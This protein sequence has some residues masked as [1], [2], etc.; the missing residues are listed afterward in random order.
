MRGLRLGLWNSESV[1]SWEMLLI[2]GVSFVWGVS[3]KTFAIILFVRTRGF[4]CLKGAL[5]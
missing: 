5:P 4:M 3:Q 1:S 2:F